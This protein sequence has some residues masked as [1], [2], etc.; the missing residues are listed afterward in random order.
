MLQH[1]APSKHGQRQPPQHD[2]ENANHNKALF[3]FVCS[4]IHAAVLL[5]VFA[6]VVSNTIPITLS[7]QFQSSRSLTVA[8][9]MTSP[10]CPFDRPDKDGTSSIFIPPIPDTR[11]GNLS[12]IS[13]PSRDCIFFPS[14]WTTA[15]DGGFQVSFIF[16]DIPAADCSLYLYVDA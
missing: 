8:S 4:E 13:N 2:A 11:I 1:P 15:L 14:Q 16:L 7:L 5:P 12:S 9:E 10:A 3:N 6:D